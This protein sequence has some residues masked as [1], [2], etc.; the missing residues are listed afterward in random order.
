[1]KSEHFGK[2]SLL[3][4]RLLSS[5]PR[6]RDIM[7]KR[8]LNLILILCVVLVTSP[9][10]RAEAADPPAIEAK[11][12]QV[13]RQMT[14]YL[15]SLEQFSIRAENTIEEVLSTGLKLQFTHTVNIYV[16]RPD[17]LRANGSGD[18]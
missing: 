15:K 1:M 8:I 2:S 6:G 11:A 5:F 12:D 13:L 4:Y 14:D 18:K 17:R 9:A 7:C 16:R 10:L 3:K